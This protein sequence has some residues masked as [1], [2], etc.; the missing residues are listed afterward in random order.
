MARKTLKFEMNPLL[1]GPSLESRARTGSPYREIS[2]S[3]IDV[4]PDQPRRVFDQAA[5]NELATSIK[6]YGVLCPILVRIAEGGTYRVVAGERRL[7]AAKLA[8]LD[9]IP[10]VVDSDKEDGKDVLA[11]QLV[12]NLQRQDLSSMERALAI[13]QLRE[14]FSWSVR[15]VATH[16]GV[17]KSFVQRCIEVLELPD[18]LQA[19]LIA[20]APESKI[21]LLAQIKDRAKRKSLIARL[22]Q[23]SRSALEEELDELLGRG[24][25]GDE[26]SHGGT[27]RKKRKGPQLSV[28]DRRIV[29]EIQRTLGTKV[30]IARKSGDSGKGRLTLEFYSPTDL[31]EIYRRL[32]A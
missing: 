30:E 18:D 13:G 2:I 28:E 16:L 5:L 27:K 26:V 14:Q 10:A 25:Q 8:G 29:E 11:K 21:L 9:R 20:G 1:S 31:Y 23:L 32:T 22:E 12:E 15:E 4:D 6:E 3:D 17:S 24:G 7:R 19:A